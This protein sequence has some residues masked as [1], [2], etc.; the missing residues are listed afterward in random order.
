[1]RRDAL[2]GKKSRPLALSLALEHRH[3]L[4]LLFVSPAVFLLGLFLVYPFLLGL[5]LSFTDT[6]IGGT[7][8]FIGLR[9]YISLW[10]DSIFQLATFNTFLYTTVAVAFKLVLGLALALLLNHEFSGKGL[11]RAIALLPW[12]V[13]TAFSAISF[14]W[15]YDSTFSVITWVLMKAGLV[16]QRID[17]LGDP[18]LAR[19]SV[20]IANIWRG[21]PF[22]AISLLAGLQTISPTLSEAAQIDGAGAWARFRYIT[23]PLL[24]PLLIVVTT[25]STIWTFADFHLVWIITKGGPANATHLYGTLAYQRAIQGGQFGEGAAISTF[26]FPVLLLSVTLS[27]LSLRRE[28]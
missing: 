13:P 10:S 11:I 4:G 21:V 12:I 17:F 8:R 2:G 3:L 27:F 9:N 26:I 7:G 24:M 18:N 28:E 19:V 6:L 5:W 20:I 16:S 25:F 14:W 1:M 23:L 15:M 22:F